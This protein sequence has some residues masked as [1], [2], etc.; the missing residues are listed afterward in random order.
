MDMTTVPHF[1]SENKPTPENLAELLRR[2]NEE[3]CSLGITP[4]NLEFVSEE[5]LESARRANARGR[6]ISLT[7]ERIEQTVRR[8]VRNFA[9]GRDTQVA[10]APRRTEPRTPRRR[11]RRA[12]RSG[13]SP[14]SDDDP[15][16]L[17]A[18]GQQAGR[19]R[20][21]LVGI[22]APSAITVSD[23]TCLAV[24]GMEPRFFRQFVRENLI[25]HIKVHRRTIAKVADVI[26]VFDRLAGIEAA[27]T[28][29]SWN[30]EDVIRLAC[31]NRGGR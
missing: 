14:P 27:P 15:Y 17:I 29:E 20:P 25:P 11:E 13:T 23:A 6:A 21:R 31:G 26:A 10:R 16:P 3:A 18:L 4:D 12:R 5:L 24:L 30:A 1:V 2:A 9:R 28:A 22:K 19:D 7:R 8:A